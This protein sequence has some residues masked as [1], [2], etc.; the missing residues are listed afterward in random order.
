MT[1]YN[2]DVKRTYE[3]YAPQINDAMDEIRRDYIRSGVNPKDVILSFDDIK[4]LERKVREIT[5]DPRVRLMR[6]F[7]EW[8]DSFDSFGKLENIYF[9]NGTKYDKAEWLDNLLSVRNTKLKL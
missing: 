8:K 9:D 1:K 6:T 3:L 7:D 2:N 5:G 4:N